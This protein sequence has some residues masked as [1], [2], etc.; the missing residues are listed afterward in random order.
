[1]GNLLESVQGPDVVQSVDA[2]RETSVETEDL[3]I[4]QGG[5]RKVIKQVGKIFPDI[6][7][8]VLSQAFVIEP[9]HLYHK[10]WESGLQG[11]ETSHS[12]LCY[13]TRFVVA[14]ENCD[15]LSESDL[16]VIKY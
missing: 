9:I 1:M 5:E 11:M 4:H 6:G 10:Y 13:L 14:S 2:G 7:V 8:A 3:T 16:F 15:S 12:H